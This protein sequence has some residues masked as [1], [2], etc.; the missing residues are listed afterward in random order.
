MELSGWEL[1]V[2]WICGHTALESK[3]SE[4]GGEVLNVS[5]LQTFA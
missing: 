2:G 3:Q 4:V 5:L 1:G